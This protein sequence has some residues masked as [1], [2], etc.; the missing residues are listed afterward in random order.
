MFAWSAAY[1]ASTVNYASVGS[2]AG[3]SDISAKT[4][5]FGASDAPLDPAQRAA[6]PGIATLPESA[7]GVV[8]IYNLPGV[9]TTLK[10]TGQVLAA[11]YLGDITSWNDSALQSINPGV[12]LPA[13]SIVVVHRSDGSGT[14]FVWSSFLSEAN[15]TWKNTVGHSTSITWPV[16]VGAVGDAGVAAWVKSTADSVGYVDLT[17]AL[18]DSVAY[19]SVENPDGDYILANVTN[20]E[21]SIS[22]ANPTFP[23]PTGDW[24]NVSVLNA[25]GPQ[26]YPVATLTYVLVYQDLSGAYPTYTLTKAE[27][28][29]NFLGWMVTVG[30]QYSAALY[31]APLP[32]STVSYDETA[33]NSITF[34]S[35]A[36]PR[37]GPGQTPQTYTVTFAESGLPNGTAWAVTLE[38]SVVRTSTDEVTASEPNGTLSYSISGVP[39]WHQSTL[40]YS[41]NLTVNG[42]PVSEPNLLFA[43]VTYSVTFTETG[44]PDGVSWS[45]ALAG[46]PVPSTTDSLLFTEPNGSYTFTVGPVAGYTV[47]RSVVAIDVQGLAESVSLLFI[48]NQTTSPTF[49]GLPANEGYALVGGVTAAALVGVVVGTL[50]RRRGK[51]HS[52][53]PASPPGA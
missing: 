53:P 9:S 42:G 21:S 30:Q 8:P 1:T 32:P 51:A 27:N 26:D 23:A 22:D 19:G 28:L 50:L 49:L 34:N 16:G 10:L 11:I 29:A 4:V 41:G 46:S 12:T 47:N 37:C 33:I 3:I 38:G 40:R 15:S 24:Y 13:A 36:I 45:V 6:A 52:I 14:T 44:L 17:Y 31:Y 7:G 20:I 48:S 39:G 5:D 43:R 25:P 18:T 2:G 35:S